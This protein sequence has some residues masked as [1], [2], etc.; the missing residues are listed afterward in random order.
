MILKVIVV[1]IISAIIGMLLGTIT[2]FYYKISLHNLKLTN[3]QKLNFIYKCLS[4]E[5]FK[6]YFFSTS[7]L[8]KLIIEKIKLISNEYNY[9]FQDNIQL[10]KESNIKYLDNYLIT[11]NTILNYSKNSGI[12]I[13]DISRQVLDKV[14]DIDVESEGKFNEVRKWEFKF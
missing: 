8:N 1:I 14:D 9:K 2:N 6:K 10:K 4:K 5:Y 13:E 12:K 11:F 3:I 7:D